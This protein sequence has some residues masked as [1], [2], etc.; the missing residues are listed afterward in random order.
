MTMLIST[1]EE[2]AK[3]FGKTRNACM[4]QIR[5]GRLPDPRQTPTHATEMAWPVGDKRGR[6][7]GP[8]AAKVS[9]LAMIDSLKS[10]IEALESLLIS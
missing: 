7:P 8:S 10:R 2:L 9:M 1:I 3:H 5:L 6:K 4:Y